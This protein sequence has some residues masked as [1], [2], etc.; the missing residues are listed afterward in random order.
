MRVAICFY[1]QP[2]KYKQVLDQWQKLIKELEADVF[3]HSWYGIDRGRNE[4][5]VNELTKDFNPKEIEVS[6]KH[7]FIDLI[8][9]DSTYQNQ[10]YHAMQQSYTIT[11]CFKLLV[12]HSINFNKKY[13]IIIKTRMDIELQNVD[14]LIDFVKSKI[15]SDKLYVAGNH[16][17]GG[18]MFDDNIMVAKSDILVHLFLQYFKYTIQFINNTKLIPGGEQ[19]IF[20]YINNMGVLNLIDKTTPLNFV[21]IPYKLEEIILN[22]NEK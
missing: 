21:L 12:E 5:D 20:N 11:K 2:R 10:S 16:W 7:K 19:N 17:Q 1:G 14:E 15:E 13:D 22:E 18:S 9:S 6:D 3:I 8:P 4:I